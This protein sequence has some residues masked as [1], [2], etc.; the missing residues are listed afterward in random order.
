MSGE[1]WVLQKSLYLNYY[2]TYIPAQQALE[3]SN[4][5][6]KVRS[7][8]HAAR[9]TKMKAKKCAGSYFYVFYI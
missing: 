8:S 5:L 4:P 9:S 1:Q 2:L 6:F 3:M 7:I